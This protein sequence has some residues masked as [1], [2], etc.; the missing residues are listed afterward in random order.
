MD[1]TE[2]LK[3]S[4]LD[5]GNELVYQYVNL[6]VDAVF[7]TFSLFVFLDSKGQAMS[8]TSRAMMRRVHDQ[9]FTTRYFVGN[10]IDIDCGPD[11]IAQYYE[12]F[13]LIKSV[14]N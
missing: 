9:R 4:G 10:G 13:P 5:I 14:K 1:R 6:E 3:R 7:T 11:P 2:K 12:Q 8:G